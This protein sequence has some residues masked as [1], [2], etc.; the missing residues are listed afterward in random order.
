[1][2]GSTQWKNKNKGRTE[3]DQKNKLTLPNLGL[4]ITKEKRR[5][6]KQGSVSLLVPRSPKKRP[7]CR[8][9][10]S[11]GQRNGRKLLKLWDFHLGNTSKSLEFNPDMHSVPQINKYCG[12]RYGQKHFQWSRLAERKYIYISSV[13]NDDEPNHSSLPQLRAS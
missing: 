2:S 10:Q 1:M 6:L 9:R 12:T 8:S 5:K 11:C 3:F 4:D 7:W 13:L